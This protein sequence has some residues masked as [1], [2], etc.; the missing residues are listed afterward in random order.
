MVVGYTDGCGGHA[1]NKELSRKRA[2]EIST[3]I[4]THY[5]GVSIRM[6]WI[7]EASGEHT[8]AARRVDVVTTKKYMV[9]DQEAQ[10]CSSQQVDMLRKGA[11]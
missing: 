10:E 3:Y 4:K 9:T 11:I 1:Y 8:I 6:K 2:R 5:T 7:G